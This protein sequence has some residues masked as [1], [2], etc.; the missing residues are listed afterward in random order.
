M[1]TP[2]YAYSL[3][4]THILSLTHSLSLTLLHTHIQASQIAVV[5]TRLPTTSQGIAEPNLLTEPL[6]RIKTLGVRIIV[7]LAYVD[8][9]LECGGACSRGRVPYSRGF[10]GFHRVSLYPVLLVG[11]MYRLVLCTVYRM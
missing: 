1:L 4:L 8:G 10:R 3:S 6:K 7:L 5:D 9:V 2:T 11:S